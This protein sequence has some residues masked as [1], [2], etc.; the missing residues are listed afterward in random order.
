MLLFRACFDPDVLV[1]AFVRTVQAHTH[2][3]RPMISWSHYHILSAATLLYIQERS[4]S[5]ANGVQG[6]AFFFT[7]DRARSS[8]HMHCVVMCIVFG[9]GENLKILF[10]RDDRFPFNA[11]SVKSRTYIGEHGPVCVTPFFHFYRRHGCSCFRVFHFSTICNRRIVLQKKQKLIDR[12]KCVECR[13]RKF[14]SK[15]PNYVANN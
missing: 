14:V 1:C 11:F 2:R 6:T 9:D 7:D 15:I 10:K 3:L 5:A 12:A 4:G 13:G 8:T